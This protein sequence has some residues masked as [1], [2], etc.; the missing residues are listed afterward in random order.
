MTRGR[1]CFLF[2]VVSRAVLLLADLKELER[3]LLGVMLMRG[4]S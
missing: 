3:R 1:G 4:P 2:E